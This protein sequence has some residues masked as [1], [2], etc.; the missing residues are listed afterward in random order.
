MKYLGLLLGAHYK[1][2]TIWNGMIETTE[3]RLAGWKL[4]LLSKGKTHFD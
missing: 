3:R 1:D 2:N 4:A